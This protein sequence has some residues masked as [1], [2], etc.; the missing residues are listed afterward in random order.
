MS[1]SK[2]SLTNSALIEIGVPTVL[3][4]DEDSEAARLANTVFDQLLD[5]ELE[6][7]DWSFARSRQQLAAEVAGPAFG[8]TYSHVLPSSPYCLHVLEEI[9]KA[10]YKIEGRKILSDDTPLQIRFTYRVTDMNELSAA[11][12]RAFVFKLAAKLSLPLTGSAERKAGMEQLYIAEI[13]KAKTRDSQQDAQ[14]Q[15]FADDDLGWLNARYT[16]GD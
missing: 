2:T 14:Q 9:N 4:L 12:R 6:N 5:E 8:Y 7:H 1:V 10:E 15:A 16:R 3:N 11:F 13:S